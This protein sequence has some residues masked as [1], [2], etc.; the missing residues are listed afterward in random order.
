M[1]GHT[2]SV[3]NTADLVGRHTYKTQCITPSSSPLK[4]RGR[5][6]CKTYSAVAWNK[7]E[8]KEQ[9]IIRRVSSPS[10]GLRLVPRLIRPTV[11]MTMFGYT[12]S[13]VNTADLVGH[14]TYKTQCITPSSSPLKKRGRAKS[15]TCSAVAWNKGESKEQDLLRRVSSRS[16][17][18]RLVP[19]LIRSTVKTRVNG[20]W[21]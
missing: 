18:L 12:K 11:E 21:F 13:I 5:A 1:F 4:K 7:G 15:K 8:S 9:D 14:H 3:E 6:K 10:V 16:V 2:K 20:G 17:G 19:R